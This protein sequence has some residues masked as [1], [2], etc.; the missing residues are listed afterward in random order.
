MS[1]YIIDA[2]YDAQNALRGLFAD[3]LS[4]DIRLTKPNTGAGVFTIPFP[5]LINVIERNIDAL[6]A[7]GYRPG[8]MAPTMNWQGELNDARRL[9]YTDVNRWFESAEL[10]TDLV[11]AIG[12]R[13]LITGRFSTGDN[14]TR[15]I[16]KSVN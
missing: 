7:G 6:S 16:L 11:W 5:D 10:I 13:G 15:Q 14:R 8:D 2:A 4:R 1:T 12:A 3:L 9:D